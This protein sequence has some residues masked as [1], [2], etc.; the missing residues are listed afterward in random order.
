MPVNTDN[1]RKLL[2][3]VD[4]LSLVASTAKEADTIRNNPSAFGAGSSCGLFLASQSSRTEN[5]LWFT[6]IGADTLAFVAAR[7]IEELI[8]ADVEISSK[9]NSLLPFAGMTP[10]ALRK[11]NLHSGESVDELVNENEALK[12]ENETLKAEVARL[13]KIQLELTKPAPSPEPTSE[14][15]PDAVSEAQRILAD[16]VNNL[17]SLS[18]TAAG[19]RAHLYTLHHAV[20]MTFPKDYKPG[21][22]L[23]DVVEDVLKWTLS[24]KPD[25]NGRVVTPITLPH[26]NLP[27]K[28]LADYA[29]A[30]PPPSLEAGA[31]MS[32]GNVY[33]DDRMA[34]HSI[35]PSPEDHRNAPGA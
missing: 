24:L 13:A 4:L 30:T 29:E 15:S 35:V 28:N 23:F 7:C 8:E 33:T 6:D 10:K 25:T 18:G 17:N 20:F 32:L 27:V 11:F 14:L 9:Y 31:V 21:H 26:V 12:T 22:P 16:M 5:L 34:Y 1:M 19:L 3:Y 2:E